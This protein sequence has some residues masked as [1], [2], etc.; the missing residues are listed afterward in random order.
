MEE[1]EDLAAWLALC[2]RH[3][4]PLDRAGVKCKPCEANHRF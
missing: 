1:A 4:G 2:T 3:Y